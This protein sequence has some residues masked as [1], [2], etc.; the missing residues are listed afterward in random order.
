M[1]DEHLLGEGPFEDGHRRGANLPHP[2]M[3]ITKEVDFFEVMF[4]FLR[5]LHSPE[6][7]T[8]SVL[9][10]LRFSLPYAAPQRSKELERDAL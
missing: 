8:L 10:S 3:G 5:E 9:V 4:S 1:G 6:E 2:G 7:M